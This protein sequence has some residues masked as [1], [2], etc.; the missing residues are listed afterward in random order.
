MSTKKLTNA[1]LNSLVPVLTENIS[2][3]AQAARDGAQT[4]VTQGSGLI[5][6][7]GDVSR[8]PQ[9]FGF[10]FEH[11]HAI[12]FNINAALQ[13]SEARA[14]QIPADGST[15]FSPDIYVELTGKVVAAIQAKAGSVQYVEQQVK[16]GHY[17]EV[18][19]T[20]AENAGV[21]GTIDR[22]QVNDVQSIPIHSDLARF[23]ADYPF[24]S[25]NLIKAA[26]TAGEVTLA[27]AQSAVIQT[28]IEM[29]LQ[30]IKVA[31]AY[32]RGEEE[33]ALAEVHKIH[34]IALKSLREG[35]IRGVAIRI[36]QRV[37]GTKA[38]ASLGFTVAEVA[39]PLVIQV[40][41][42]ELSLDVAVLQ[43]G[44]QAFTAAAI[45][46]VILLFPPVGTAL[47]SATIIQAI[48]AEISPEWKESICHT[49]VTTKNRVTPLTND[50]LLSNS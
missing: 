50:L 11:L 4:M 34:E 30:L 41:R 19:L 48:W 6:K 24:L 43:V 37:T 5:T 12:G 33:L 17:Q 20:N 49:V 42:N 27:G 21:V 46:P 18:I 35:F 38:I 25:A 28:E 10:A 45:I 15:K 1:V 22:I 29:L 40:L 36:L 32:C 31:G 39:C 13:K 8:N 3:A 44:H 26:A 16:T 23:I 47:V 7:A 14:Y 2:T 9:A